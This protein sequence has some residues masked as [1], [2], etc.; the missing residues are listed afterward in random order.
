MAFKIELCL[1]PFF[2]NLSAWKFNSWTKFQKYSKLTVA[3]V[4]NT[5]KWKQKWKTQ[6]ASHL[7]KNRLPQQLSSLWN[8]ELGISAGLLPQF[9]EWDREFSTIC[10]ELLEPSLMLPT[11]TRW[12]SPLLRRQHFPFISRGGV[13]VKPCVLLMTRIGSHHHLPHP[14]W[15]PFQ[16]WSSLHYS[17][18]TSRPVSLPW[19]HLP[20]VFDNPLSSSHTSY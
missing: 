3:T 14:A 6:Q 5:V 12:H 11:S 2:S 13:K 4:K 16:P 9:P 10:S 17:C 1:H 15:L 20:S 18:S 19:S 8:P 7:E